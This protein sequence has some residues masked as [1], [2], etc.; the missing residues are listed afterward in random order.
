LEQV[1]RTQCQR[2]RECREQDERTGRL[3]GGSSRPER[4]IRIKA[5]KKEIVGYKVGKPKGIDKQARLNV[6][7]VVTVGEKN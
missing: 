5:K 7:A 4:M 6:Q 1:I 3:S 2:W